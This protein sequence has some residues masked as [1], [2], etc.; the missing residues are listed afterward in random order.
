MEM[1]SFIFLEIAQNVWG[2]ILF[3]L[4]PLKTIFNCMTKR[5][6]CIEIK[7]KQKPELKYKNENVSNV[8]MHTYISIPNHPVFVLA[9]LTLL[10]CMK[11]VVLE[12]IWNEKASALVIS[13]IF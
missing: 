1:K 2:I 7:H 6:I 3:D 8:G 5:A 11:V 10:N 12:L 9:T 4:Y 13:L